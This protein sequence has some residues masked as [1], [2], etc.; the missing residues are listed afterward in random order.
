MS[1]AGVA[2]GCFLAGNDAET[3]RE[4][5]AGIAFAAVEVMAGKG[6][7]MAE[8]K[9]CADFCATNERD[10]FRALCDAKG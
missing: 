5:L 4:T 9:A 1:R 6:H 2:D 3:F 8:A 10:R 7:D